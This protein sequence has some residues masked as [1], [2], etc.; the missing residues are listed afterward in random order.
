M[1]KRWILSGVA[2]IALVAGFGANEAAASRVQGEISTEL[3]DNK[4]GHESVTC[5]GLYPDFTCAISQMRYEGVGIKKVTFL[6]IQGLEKMHRQV[7]GTHAFGLEIEGIKIEDFNQPWMFML[8]LL[9]GGAFAQTWPMVETFVFNDAGKISLS[10]KAVLKAG[11]ISAMEDFSLTLRNNFG[12]SQMEFSAFYAENSPRF[13]R[14]NVALNLVDLREIVDTFYR[15][16]ENKE[17]TKE[18]LDEAFA[19]F[20]ADALAEIEQELILSEDPVTRDM[21]AA[22]EQVLSEKSKQILVRV[23]AKDAQGLDLN[24]LSLAGQ[25]QLDVVISN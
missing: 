4:I 19:A 2:A 14:F 7:E 23:V 5:S 22:L 12:S 20:K 11:E 8:N 18:E 10:G 1:K 15:L 16:V 3:T 24:A 13:T 9:S 21:L 6:N 17:A 25:E